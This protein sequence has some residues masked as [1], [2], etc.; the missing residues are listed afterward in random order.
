LTDCGS[1]AIIDIKAAG[2]YSHISPYLLPYLYPPLLAPLKS[3]KSRPNW[4]T[5]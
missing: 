2:L 5:L 3:L 1:E 4:Y